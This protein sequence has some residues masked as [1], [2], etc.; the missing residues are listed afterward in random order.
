M[1]LKIDRV[2]LE[3]VIKNDQSRKRL[4]E[5]EDQSRQLKKELKKLPEGTEA[6]TQKFNQ[7]KKVQAEMD[8]LIDKI[9]LTGLSMKE[10]SQRQKEL[11]SI[12]RNLDPRTEEYKKLDAQLQKVKL[13]MNEL[14]IGTN[15]TKI[16][17]RQI[18]DTMNRFSVLGASVIAAITGIVYSIAQLVQGT[19][20]L[21]DSLSNV[22]KTT[23]L[24]RKEVRELYSDFRFLN[25]RT[26]RKELLGLAEEAGRLG[27]QGKKDIMEFVEVG[28]K[29]KT[30]L[31]DDLGD[32]ADKAILQVGK[33][34]TL[35][36]VAEKQG[37]DYGRA[38][39]MVGS[40]INELAANTMAQAPYLI[41]FTKRTMGLGNQAKISASQLIGMAAAFDESG[42][43][44]ELSATAVNKVIVD[45]FRDYAAYADVAK[46]KSEEFFNLLKTDANAAFIKL[47]EGINGNN[48]GFA[49]MVQKF[50]AIGVDGARATQALAALASNLD[51]L[52]INQAIANKALIEGTSLTNEYNIKNDNLAGSYEKLGRYIR[53]AFI[54][55]SFLGWL[56]NVIGKMAEWTKVPLSEKLK[57]DQISVNAM[58]IEMTS[59]NTTAKRRNEIYEELDRIYPGIIEGIDKENINVEKL[60]SNLAKYNEEMI[61]KIAL[62]DSEETLADKRQ[63]LGEKLSERVNQEQKVREAMLKMNDWFAKWRK[64]KVEEARKIT[65]SNL[66]ILEKDKQLRKLYFKDQQV[67]PEA[68]NEALFNLFSESKKLKSLREEELDL[69]NDFNEALKVYEDMYNR[70]MNRGDDATLNSTKT[71]DFDS[72]W[73]DIEKEL[74][75]VIT[76]FEPIEVEIWKPKK[77]DPKN[78]SNQEITQIL[79]L[80]N[81]KIKAYLDANAQEISSLEANF[82]REET[83]RRTEFNKQYRLLK[84]D[85]KAQKQL[86]DKF[87]TDELQ[88]KAEHLKMLT[89][90]LENQLRTGTGLE[91]VILSDEENAA[92]QEKLDQ[93][94]LALSEIGIELDNLPNTVSSSVD[95]KLEG[96]SK[97]VQKAASIASQLSNA[98][99]GVFSALSAKE[100]TEMQQYEYNME[101]RKKLLEDQ[102]S[103]GALSQEDYNKQI[104]ALDVKADKKRRELQNEQAKRDK[105]SAI[106][107][108]IINTAQA[109]ASA[110]ATPPAPLGI[111]LAA[112]VGALGAVQVGVIA[113]TKVPQYASGN[114]LDIIGGEDGKTYHAKI[115][116]NKTQ[117]VN[118]PTFVPGLGLTG[119]GSKPRELVF[120]GDDTQRILNTPALIDAINYTIRAPQFANGNYPTSVTERT[121]EKTFT[122]PQLIKS[123]NGFTEI[124]TQIKREGLSVPWT[125]IDEKNQKMQQLKNSI[126]IK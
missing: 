114:Y 98:I 62:Q 24:T 92:L 69:Q 72:Y 42:Q 122:D 67:L 117:I 40:S 106:F 6:W 83:L 102:L 113:K 51:R 63:D 25:T 36:K 99:G 10:L 14:R 26:A 109:V 60:S 115:G 70:I 21:D 7:L 55:S 33:I 27:K 76:K 78:L 4:R 107:G 2:Q 35:L 45:M 104:S 43:N 68:S 87:N 73:S 108:A 123:L 23:G 71:F 39:D 46:M 96:I 79:A 88:S 54:N 116:E 111:A 77:F 11:N 90:V 8:E 17:L 56:E 12:M 44:L 1:S 110:L 81:Q 121:F 93:L 49:T 100:N 15:R 31:G 18:A 91:G 52:K 22:M 38:M 32:S 9:G 105:T 53:A 59:F 74:E 34:T 80:S 19:V 89:A 13:R 37:V 112:I 57:K 3:I 85:Q 20:N 101:R 118:G 28:N 103:S 82:K 47:L 64:D 125:K 124:M 48:E 58:V 66:D 29:I 41:E 5:L 126:S 16:S 95:G 61:K 30:A 65:L 86:T 120:S 50:D 97:T 75:T 94:K 119:E 84:G